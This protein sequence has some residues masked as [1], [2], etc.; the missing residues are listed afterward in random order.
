MGELSKPVNEPTTYFLPTLPG[1]FA[2]L[3]T[4]SFDPLVAYRLTSGATR[5]G[6]LARAVRPS[7]V[8]DKT[9]LQ[10]CHDR[11]V[12]EPNHF[13]FGDRFY[14]LEH[15][16]ERLSTIRYHGPEGL[17]KKIDIRTYRPRVPFQPR[18]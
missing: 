7:E 1:L 16:E 17:D 9:A 5:V 3:R 12:D 4:A 14:E 6:V 18:T 8:R 10:K 13:A 15:G 11:Y 2:M